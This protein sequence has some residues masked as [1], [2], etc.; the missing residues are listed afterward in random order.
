MSLPILVIGATGQQGGSV[1]NALLAKGVKVRGLT[2]KLDSAKA[3]AL[4]EQGVKMVQGD[5]DHADSITAAAQNVSVAWF[6]STPFEAGE[7][8]ATKQGNATIDALKA[9]KVPHIVFSSVASADKKTGIPHFDSKFKVEEYLKASGIPYTITAP[10]YFCDSALAPWNLP[11]LK[12]GVYGQ[13]MPADTKLQVISVRNIGRFNA[14]ILSSPSVYA[15]RRIDI[16]GD[17]V[18]ATEQAAAIAKGSAMSEDFAIMYEWFISTG[19]TV[20]LESLHKEFASVEWQSMEDWA[21]SMDWAR[22]M[23]EEA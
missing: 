5:F 17:S 11:Y 23:K 20:D 4:K 1:V 15:S 6:M 13:P 2:R 18:S 7:A 22:I 16:A 21:A 3:V 10:V 19:Y 14:E 9:A 8:A 12:K